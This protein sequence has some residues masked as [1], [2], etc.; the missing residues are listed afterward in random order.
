MLST[1]AAI[2]SGVL[3][4]TGAAKVARP[5]DVARALRTLGLPKIPGVGVALGVL[6]IVVGVG[7]LVAPPVLYAQ[8]ILYLVFAGWVI[9]ALRSNVPI[10]SCGCLGRDDTPPT[11]AHIVFNVLASL[12]SFGAAVA[13]TPLTMGMDF[14]GVAEVAVI[15]VGIYLSYVLLTDAAA[16]VGVRRRR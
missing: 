4:F 1:S 2:F 10:A 12:V 5:H 6:E 11:V 7:A 13:G 14:G 16:L 8:A 9:W 3:V 15:G